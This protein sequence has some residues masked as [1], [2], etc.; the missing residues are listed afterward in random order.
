MHE[1]SLRK[2]RSTVTFGSENPTKEEWMLWRREQSKIHIPTFKLLSLLGRCI[3]PLARVWR[4]Y[5]DKNKDKIQEKSEGGTE[6]YTRMDGKSR[7]YS[8]SHRE[9]GTAITG[10]PVTI[11]KLEDGALRVQE[12]GHDQVMEADKEH[13]GFLTPLRNYGWGVVLGGHPNS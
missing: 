2:N 9:A 6:V 11:A 13:E 3:H 12:V 5:Y 1:G 8:H 7:R 4:Y 10:H